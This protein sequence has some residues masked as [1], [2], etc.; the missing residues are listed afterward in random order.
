GAKGVAGVL[1][2]RGRGAQEGPGQ[3]RSIRP[4]ADLS[5]NPG[6]LARFGP[7]TPEPVD[8]EADWADQTD[9]GGAAEVGR[10]PRLAR[11]MMIK[12]QSTGQAVNQSR[13]AT[14]WSSR[15]S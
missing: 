10:P 11:L 13:I 1:G 4:V 6:N 14:L 7:T 9:A 2:R 12:G 3:L 15:F 8:L 5:L